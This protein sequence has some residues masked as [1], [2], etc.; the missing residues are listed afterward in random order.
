MSRKFQQ[1]NKDLVNL[2]IVESNEVW[3]KNNG[4][5]IMDTK[6]YDIYGKI[7]KG[8]SAFIVQTN[9]FGERQRYVEDTCKLPKNAK[10]KIIDMFNNKNKRVIYLVKKKTK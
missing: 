5:Y 8:T 4:K 9:R 2:D 7:E 1:K 6:N 3:K 10:N